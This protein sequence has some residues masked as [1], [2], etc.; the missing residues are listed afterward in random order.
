M[1]TNINPN[2]ELLSFEEMCER[3][4]ISESV[5]YKL[6]KDKIKA[7]KIGSWK[8]PA[9]SVDQFIREQCNFF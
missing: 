6:L 2:E 1:M 3:L 9:S 7:F 8:I 5:G 4:M